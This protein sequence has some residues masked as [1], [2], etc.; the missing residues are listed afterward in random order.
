M[1]FTAI[2]SVQTKN[3]IDLGFEIRFPMQFTAILFKLK[4]S[5]IWGLRSD[6]F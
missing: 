5:L 2:I 4:V 3:S 6:D 1:Q